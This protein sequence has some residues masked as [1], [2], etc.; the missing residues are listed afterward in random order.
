[1]RRVVCFDLGDVLVRLCFA[2]CPQALGH[3]C[4]R[5]PG[6]L[7]AASRLFLDD[8]ALALSSGAIGPDAF[9]AELVRGFG[10]P[11]LDRG[12]AAAAWCS[13]FDPWPDMTDL[14]NQTIDA[15][16]EVWLLSNTD[17]M[18]MAYLWPR[19]PVL[20]RFAGLHL[21]YEVGVNK[22]DPAFFERFLARSGAAPADC[23]FLDDRADN[24]AAAQALGLATHL[25]RGDGAAARKAIADFGVGALAVEGGR[26]QVAD[27]HRPTT[28]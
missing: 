8:R 10:R 4:G 21:S 18:H 5:G 26:A 15:G 2:R 17:P 24:I 1:V 23:L 9:L 22:P 11:D 13:I 16:A 14:A 12:L 28:A 3:L 25:H 6:D 27:G 19:M 7:S 20:A